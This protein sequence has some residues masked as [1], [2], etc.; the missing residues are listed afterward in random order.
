[1]D[2]KQGTAIKLNKI[3]ETEFS[4]G[5]INKKAQNPKNRISEILKIEFL[6]S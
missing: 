6:K 5:G 2:F 1:M 3:L 4:T